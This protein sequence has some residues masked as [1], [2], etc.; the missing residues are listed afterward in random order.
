MEK[1]TFE[2]AT[3]IT[4]PQVN[5]NDGFNIGSIIQFAGATIPS[6]WLLCDGS[7]LSRTTYAD[8]FNAIGTTYGV[9]DGSTTFNLPNLKGRVVVGQDISQTEFDTLGETG[10]EKA[11]T[12]TINEIPPHNHAI[13]VD[14]TGTGGIWGPMGTQQQSLQRNA[15]TG[16]TGGGQPHNILQ[17][18]ITLN[19]IIKAISQETSLNVIDAVTSGGTD[20]NANTFNTM[21]DNIENAI[22]D[23]YSTS[24]VKTNKVW[25]DSKPIYRKTFVFN[26]TINPGT[27]GRLV[28]S[29]NIS[30]VNDI[31]ID[32]AHSFIKASTTTTR[33]PLPLLLYSGQ[34][35]AI[36]PYVNNTA[37]YIESQTPWGENWTKTIT[38]EYT[39]TTD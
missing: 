16:N 26:T 22:V 23:S 27:E 38:L 19:Y 7:E 32:T 11:H 36:Y 35:D 1:I 39:K 12:L 9:G 20:L 37:I 28:V 2:D 3:I 5:I 13:Y 17:P 15:I 14:E 29:H 10:G 6:G 25:I 8:L 24:E 31:W 18:Y 33:F 21:Q 4:P 30:N 34:I